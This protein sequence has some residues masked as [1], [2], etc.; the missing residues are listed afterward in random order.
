MKRKWK[1]NLNSAHLDELRN[2]F[3]IIM[4]LV[5]DS[6]QIVTITKQG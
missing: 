3:M 1:K 4:L 2:N 6:A 5:G